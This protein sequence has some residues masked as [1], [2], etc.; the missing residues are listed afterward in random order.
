MR[1]VLL[2]T[3]WEELWNIKNDEP[4]A[5]L[6]G[7]GTDLL[8]RLC[9]SNPDTRPIIALE[10]IE[11]LQQIELTQSEVII[12]AMAT[13]QQ[14]LDS[15][16]INTHLPVLA[17]AAAMLGSPPIRHMGTIG[18]NICTA[19][20]AGDTL[21]P[22][23]VLQAQLELTSRRGSRKM[24]IGDFI[25]GPGK[26]DL[27]EDEI[28]SRISI[29]LPPA[30]TRSFYYKVGQRKALAIAICS[31]AVTMQMQA[32]RIE[33]VTIAWGSVGPTVMV[34][35][36]ANEI[37]RGQKISAAL[38]KEYGRMA[39]QLVEPI[40]DIRASERYRRMLVEN[41]PLRILT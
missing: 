6:M 17:E 10:K 38:L 41:L 4:T 9:E 5:M 36:A 26:I 29:P 30:A 19:S 15:P 35:P 12:G 28:L 23:Y 22:L 40:S 3:S 24:A 14:L 25:Q 33:G 27:K 18:G 1:K 20:P 21:P 2:P 34:F 31:M 11:Q 32:D 7:G 13:H 39:A 16:I 8:V 37:L